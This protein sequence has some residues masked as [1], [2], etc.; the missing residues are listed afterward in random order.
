M[1]IMIMGLMLL[2]SVSSFASVTIQ[3]KLK[4]SVS[5]NGI[6]FP[7]IRVSATYNLQ[8]PNECKIEVGRND[9]F[10]GFIDA[11][12]F[13]C[14]YVDAT[15]T[16]LFQESALRE[17]AKRSFDFICGTNHFRSQENCSKLYVT[18]QEGDIRKSNV[19]NAVTAAIGSI[20]G[21]V[22]GV[23]TIKTKTTTNF[24]I[25]NDSD[26]VTI[27]LTPLKSIVVQ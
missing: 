7:K 24:Q 12:D 17:I 6:T 13:D 1:K 10:G 5:M 20:L 2:T 15:N 4:A 16:I 18:S 26:A 3:T 8:N 19:K 22:S 25:E 11:T 21:G 9:I 14:V 23:R 27:V